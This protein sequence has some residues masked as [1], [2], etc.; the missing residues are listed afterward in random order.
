MPGTIHDAGMPYDTLRI[1]SIG[2]NIR[3]DTVLAIKRRRLIHTPQN[4]SRLGSLA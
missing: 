1:S 3:I 4:S 2:I